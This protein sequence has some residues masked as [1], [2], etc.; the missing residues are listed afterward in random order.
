MHHYLEGSVS[1]VWA[2]ELLCLRFFLPLIV[3]GIRAG[4][5]GCALG[6]SLV[7]CL[8]HFFVNVCMVVFIAVHM[9]E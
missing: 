8:P 6:F 2:R 1:V 4:L 9:D 3:V 7:D 5:V